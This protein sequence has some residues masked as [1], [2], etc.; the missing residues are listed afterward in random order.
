MIKLSGWST[1]CVTDALAS[2]WPEAPSAGVIPLT[3]WR[4]FSKAHTERGPRLRRRLLLFTQYTW[5]EGL[6]VRSCPR[7]AAPFLPKQVSLDAEARF[8]ENRCPPL[9]SYFSRWE[10]GGE[11]CSF[12]SFPDW[13]KTRS[14]PTLT[15]RFLDPEINHS[16]EIS[17]PYVAG[18]RFNA[19]HAWCNAWF[20][21]NW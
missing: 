11:N 14:D 1:E 13:M 7:G 16:I 4:L 10:K 3:P 17:F 9:I 20:L 8:G 15:P 18:S 2:V 19:S 21:F 12:I 6:K 5:S